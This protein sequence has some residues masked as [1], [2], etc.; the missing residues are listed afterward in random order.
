MLCG[1]VAIIAPTGAL[2]WWVGNLGGVAFLALNW[3]FA[4]VSFNSLL[5]A[6]VSS[7]PKAPTEAAP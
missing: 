2:L 4:A 5:P 1:V 3:R 7:R 6:S